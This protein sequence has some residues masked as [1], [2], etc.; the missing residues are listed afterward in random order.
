MP[1]LQAA[2]VALSAR[3]RSQ[4]EALLRRQTCPQQ[5][6]LRARIV[7]QAGSG[8]GVRESARRLGVARSTVQSWRRRWAGSAGSVAERLADAP[9]PGTPATFG[10]EQICAIVAIACEAPAD[11]DR[12]ITHWTQQEIADE[13]VRRGIVAA[14]SP[15]SVGRFLKKKRTSSRTARAAG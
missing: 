8:E 13:A 2:P 3:E 14:I 6:A 10:A 1:Q 4:L 7:L 9:R 12:P 5:I 11:C 15:D